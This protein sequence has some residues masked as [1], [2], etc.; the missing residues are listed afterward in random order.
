MPYLRQWWLLLEIRQIVL[1][2]QTL[3]PPNEYPHRYSHGEFQTTI[4]LLV[5]CH[6]FINGDKAIL[7]D[8]GGE[9]RYCES[10]ITTDTWKS[11]S[12]LHKNYRKHKSQVVAPEEISKILPWIHIAISNAESLF[13][14]IYH[15]IK[16]E[17]LQEY[18]NEFCYKFNR[19]YLGERL[20]EKLYLYR[21]LMK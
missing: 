16:S 20:F 14:K 6:S 21:Q 5:Y 19:K 15:G 18:L 7:F 1:R 4:S 17:F 12:H 9:D 8:N 2:M 13:T 11:H 10:S 3:S